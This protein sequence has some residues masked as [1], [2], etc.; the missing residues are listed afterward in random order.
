MSTAPQQL[1][2]IYPPRLKTL[3]K[4]SVRCRLCLECEGRKGRQGYA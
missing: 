3:Q 2:P 1:L 4:A